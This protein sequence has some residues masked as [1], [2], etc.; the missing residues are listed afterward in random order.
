MVG[1]GH[2]CD[3]DSSDFALGYTI[4]TN[5]GLADYVTQ[6]GPI[7]DVTIGTHQGKQQVGETGSCVVAIGVSGSSRVDVIVTG[8][9]TTDPCPTALTLARM[10]EPRLP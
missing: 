4:R 10:V 7:R 9:G 8:D 3:F 6:G 5:V 1:T 2:A